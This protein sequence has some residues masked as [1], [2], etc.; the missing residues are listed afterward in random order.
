MVVI[1]SAILMATASPHRPGAM[2]VLDPNAAQPITCPATSRFEASRRDR[3]KPQ[4]RK[5]TDLPAADAYFA[6]YRRIGQCEVPM[7][8]K[9]GTGSR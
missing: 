2:P 8:V 5:L 9:Y 4:A 3:K 1:L 7:L 6:V